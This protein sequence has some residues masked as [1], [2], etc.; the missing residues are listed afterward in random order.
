MRLR[1]SRAEAPRPSSPAYQDGHI[2]G[3]P[4]SISPLLYK[5]TASN[6]PLSRAVWL[7]TSLYIDTTP[8]DPESETSF[9]QQSF[10]NVALGGVDP[11][12]AGLVGARRGGSSADV[13]RFR[14]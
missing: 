2:I 13:R 9:D 6:N 14:L 5:E 1:P 10:V 3:P 8:A 4:P 12:S 11:N 7:Q